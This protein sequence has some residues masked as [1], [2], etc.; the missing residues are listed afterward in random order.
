MKFINFSK[1][2]IVFKVFVVFHILSSIALA[3]GPLCG[4]EN[5]DLI[6]DKDLRNMEYNENRNDPGDA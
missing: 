5:L 3:N 6:I 2:L 4:N 1:T